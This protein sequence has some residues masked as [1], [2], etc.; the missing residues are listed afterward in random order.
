MSVYPLHNLT[1]WV[2]IRHK[3]KQRGK[4]TMTNFTR[5]QKYYLGTLS[6]EDREFVLSTVNSIIKEGFN[7]ADGVKKLNLKLLLETK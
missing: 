5:V 6:E 7:D 4:Q 3:I 2:I 1:G